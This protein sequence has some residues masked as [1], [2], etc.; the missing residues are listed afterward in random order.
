MS[1]ISH[2]I[3]INQKEA[4]FEVGK[5]LQSQMNMSPADTNR[6]KA[7]FWPLG[8]VGIAAA[9]YPLVRGCDGVLPVDATFHPGSAP[10]IPL[11]P[12]SSYLGAGLPG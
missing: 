7:S 9:A 10:P 1:E 12:R 5:S 11:S 4:Y 6:Y 3:A 2:F 8:R